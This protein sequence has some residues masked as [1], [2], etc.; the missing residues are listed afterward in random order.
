M[1]EKIYN[2]VGGEFK[3]L[4]TLQ[5]AEALGLAKADTLRKKIF[6][7]RLKAIK[8]GKTWFVV[9]DKLKNVKQESKN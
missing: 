9:K 5:E 7:D 4:I 2:K 6:L 1:S 8:K 3:E